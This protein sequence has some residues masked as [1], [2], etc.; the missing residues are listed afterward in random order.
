M[1]VSLR[2][3]RCAERITNW[4]N[5]REIMDRSLRGLTRDEEKSHTHASCL[6]LQKISPLS[7]SLLVSDCESFFLRRFFKENTASV[8]ERTLQTSTFLVS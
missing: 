6:F 5:S 1:I 4:E 2:K 7:L 3:T 8:N